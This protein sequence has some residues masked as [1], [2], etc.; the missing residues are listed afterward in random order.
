MDKPIQEASPQQGIPPEVDWRKHGVVPP[1]INQ[2]Q[3]GS[4]GA[5]AFVEAIDSFHAIKAGKLVLASV[6]E[7]ADC[8]ETNC[9]C[10]GGLLDRNAYECV[11]KIGGLAGQ[12]YSSSDCSCRNDSYKPVVKINGGKDVLP[13]ANETALAIAVEMQPVAVL[14]DASR[15]SF[16][17]YRSGIYNDPDCSSTHLDHALLVVGYGVMEEKE[18][19]ICQN[20]WGEPDC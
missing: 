7:F 11:V 17:L 4:S 13:R 12:D 9:G 20:S 5:F 10:D 14:I 16:Q 15:T 19:W 2:G 3:C 1:V 6:T 18:Y 8:C